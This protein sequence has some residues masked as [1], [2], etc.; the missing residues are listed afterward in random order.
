[1][2]SISYLPPPLSPLPST[3]GYAPCRLWSRLMIS[4]GRR[5]FLV[6]SGPTL[7]LLWLYH[8]CHCHRHQTSSLQAIK[9]PC[10]QARR[11]IPF[12]KLSGPNSLLLWLYHLCRTQSYFHC[13]R[14]QTS[15][16][17]VIKSSCPQAIKYPSAAS[18]P[19]P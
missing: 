5:P 11:R 1:M 13:H 15:S 2:Y 8:L 3:L 16:H 14:H 10:S 9:Q 7:L 18:H 12:F 6:L 17:Q 4:I 19:P